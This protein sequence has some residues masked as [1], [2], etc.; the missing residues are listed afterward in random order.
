MDNGVGGRCGSIQDLARNMFI[1][2][3]SSD[4]LMHIYIHIY[5]IYNICLLVIRFVA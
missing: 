4:G 1:L 3:V 2:L 5:N